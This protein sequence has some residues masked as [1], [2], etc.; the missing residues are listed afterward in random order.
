VQLERLARLAFPLAS[1][2][3][4]G[5]TSAQAEFLPAPIVFDRVSDSGAFGT[6]ELA[7]DA[8]DFAAFV[9]RS[10]GDRAF[11]VNG[12]P[13][14]GGK[15]TG[16][17]LR[18]VTAMPAGARAQVIERN[19]HVRELAARVVC[20]SGVLDEGGSIFLGLTR[21]QA[22]GYL[23]LDG[24]LYFLASQP[25]ARAGH[26]T[27]AHHSQLGT[28]EAGGCET[29]RAPTE[30]DIDLGDSL[31]LVGAP[32][33][34]TADVFIEADNAFRARFTSDQECIDY[35]VLLLTAASE[36]YRRDLGVELRIPN[37]YLRVW[38]T[39][40]PWGAITGFSNLKNVYTYWLSNANPLKSLPR[41]AVHV[42]THPI[43]G[44][45]SRGVDGICDN[46][47]AYEI[48]SV[49]GRFPYP[50]TH[51]SRYNWDLFVVCHE[52]GHTFGSPHSNLYSPPIEC[53][54]G[55][56][57]DSGT[58]MSYCH[59]TF[60]IAQVG[61]RFHAREQAK[62][63]KVIENKACP[64]SRSIQMGDYDGDGDLDSLDLTALRA[65]RSQ[66]FRSIAAEEVFDMDLDGDL[67]EADHDLLA[68]D[69]YGAPAAR[70]SVRNGLGLNP[71]TLTS[72]SAPMLGTNWRSQITAATGSSTLL[73]GYDL[74]NTGVT[75]SRGELLVSTTPYGGTKLFASTV[76]VT[77]VVAIHEILLPVDASLLGKT[78]SFQGLVTPPSGPDYYTN[79]LDVL[80]S[81]WE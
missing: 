29:F 45:T 67:D 39:T 80:L 75:T 32:T 6:V 16:L 17:E 10:N 35:T 54:D 9:E 41:A 31:P 60:G 63:R 11:R 46:V 34:R 81:S 38:N 2:F 25:G 42:L 28:L 37:G 52:L 55:S 33:L 20:F 53:Q 21:N 50:S 56:G 65:V 13:L 19:G 27:L 61:M 7:Y 79:A 72:L 15:K 49:G 43:F 73:V 8:E 78:I 26:A 62:I 47:R 14:P 71:Q 12:F 74:P 48:S 36:V 76:V 3:L 69:V 18:P 66:G 59:T 44:G 23:Y 1:I 77:S 22:H 30:I 58:I 40:P 4:A 70:A 5:A 68:E 51:T 64:K 57:P 24:E